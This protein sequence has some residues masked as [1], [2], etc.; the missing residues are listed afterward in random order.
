MGRVGFCQGYKLMDFIMK[1]ILPIIAASVSFLIS[2]QKEESLVVSDTRVDVPTLNAS[3]EAMPSGRTSYEETDRSVRWTAQDRIIAF[4]K[5]TDWGR[6]QIQARYAGEKN[7]VFDWNGGTLPSLVKEN[8][9]HY[10]A[11]YPYQDGVVCSV[12]GG[13][14]TLTNIVLPST[15]NYAEDSFANG[16]F[17]MVAACDESDLTFRNLCGVLKLHLKGKQKVSSII[18]KG[19]GDEPLSGK[20]SVSVTPGVGEPEITMAAEAETSVTLKCV[21]PVQLTEIESVDFYISLPPTEFKNGFA[22]TVIDTDDNEYV[23]KSA[24]SMTISRSIV[25]KMPEITL[26]SVSDEGGAGNL[27]KDG[28]A[29]C[30]IVSADGHYSFDAVKGNSDEPVGEVASVAVL[31]E[32]TGTNEYLSVGALVQ[33]PTYADGVV[34]FDVA[35]FKA[36]NAV[37][38]AKDASGNILWSWHIWLTDKPSRH[39]YNNGAGVMMDRHL[40][41]TSYQPGE[42]GSLG[43]FYQWGRKDPFLNSSRIDACQAA[44]STLTWPD[45]VPTSAETGTVAYAIANPTVFISA[46]DHNCYDWHYATRDDSLWKAQKTIYDPCPTGWR[47]PDGGSK[48]VW[49]TAGFVGTAC[50]LTYYGYNFPIS[51]SAYTWYPLSGFRSYKGILSFVGEYGFC[52]SVTISEGTEYVSFFRYD[53]Y[54]SVKPE[55]L[56]ERANAL[57]VRCVQES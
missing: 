4:M 9:D 32:S 12:T 15:Q 1:K 25:L 34:S 22:V 18:V 55:M 41:A 13:T 45:A 30:Y 2:C 53:M 20:A 11:L 37:I 8:L 39:T 57:S 23:F 42:V 28:T 44:K 5:S 19:N 24:K 21:S 26:P 43:L 33:N 48:G 46:D 3:I 27:S 49:K 38:A 56:F 14:Y 16:S 36:G 35:K 50:D 10:V 6:F 31:W 29:N 51:D 17:P 7:A 40:G 47:V 54:D 52:W